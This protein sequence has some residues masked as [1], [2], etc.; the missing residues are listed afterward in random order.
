VRTLTARLLEHF[1]YAAL[2]AADGYA[3]IAAFRAQPDAID[4]IL[5]DMR[6]PHM[7]GAQTL[8]EIRNIRPAARVVL[9]SGYDE[10]DVASRFAG[11][12]LASVLRKPF[13]AD[14]LRKHV[15]RA[16]S[17]SRNFIGPEY[18]RYDGPGRAT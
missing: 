10:Q 12:T 16:I 18:S 3:G 2:T 1:G 4:C 13:S 17:E 9:M 6:M 7:D 5:L 11:Q 8:G 14:M 15:R